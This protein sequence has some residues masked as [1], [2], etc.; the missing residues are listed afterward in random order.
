MK[1]FKSMPEAQRRLSSYL[2]MGNTLALM[3]SFIVGIIAG[4]LKS[5]LFFIVAV[6]LIIFC[7]FDWANAASK[8]I[9]EDVKR[10]WWP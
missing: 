8:E 7:S 10:G 6:I 1:G 3:F 2:T 5:F 4:A 9:Y